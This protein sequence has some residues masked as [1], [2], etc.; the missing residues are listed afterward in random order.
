MKYIRELLAKE[1]LDDQVK[2]HIA[3]KAVPLLDQRSR[4]EA[5]AMLAKAREFYP[6]PE[7]TLME[8]QMLP[9]DAT[10]LQQFTA[11]L[12]VLRSN[13]TNSEA[14]AGVADMLAENGLSEKAL[15]WYS[16]LIS[17]NADNETAVSETSIINYLAERYRAGETTVANDQLD[18]ILQKYPEDDQTW[19]LR[20]TTQRNDESVQMLGQAQQVFIKRLNDRCDQIAKLPLPP[21]VTPA[22][23]VIIKVV[24][25]TAQPPAENVQLA[26]AR[27]KQIGDQRIIDELV[28]SLA[29]VAWFELYFNHKAD[30]CGPA[31]IA[32]KELRP[33]DN[34]LVRRLDGWFYLVSGNEAAARKV[35]AAQ[36]AIDP[37][38]ALGLFQLEDS[39]GHTNEANI[40]GAKILSEPHVGVLGAILYQATKGRG[41][42]AASQ[43]PN[44][45]ACGMNWISFPC[46]W[47]DILRTPSTNSIPS[48]SNRQK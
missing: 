15:T 43:P 24:P 3:A 8:W 27:C 29:N 38:S 13:P 6:L 5:L 23:A 4:P 16:L 39:K 9:P 34:Y 48:A 37:L 17:V 32:I 21:G 42:K 41:I 10:K 7:V 14:I 22:P 45:A 26:I 35:F 33:A 1:T 40:I 31:M 46:E 2:A 25:A 28:E 19:F 47:L 20:L 36:Q 11:M 12:N 18:K 30:T 44:A